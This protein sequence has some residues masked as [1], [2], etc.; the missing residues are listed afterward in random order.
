MK[1][2]SET[3]GPPWRHVNEPAFYFRAHL[4]SDD[5]V[6]NP[7]AGNMWDLE[8]W[9]QMVME[10]SER[11]LKIE[12]DILFAGAGLIAQLERFYRT[13]SLYGLP[14]RR[15]EEFMSW[16]PTI[17]GS[18]RRRQ[19]ASKTSFNPSWSWSGWVGEVGWHGGAAESVKLEETQVYINKLHKLGDRPLVLDRDSPSLNDMTT[20][21]FPFLLIT[22]PTSVFQVLKAVDTPDWVQELQPLAWYRVLPDALTREAV[23]CIYSHSDPPEPMGSVVFDSKIDCNFDQAIDCEFINISSLPQRLDVG[24]YAGQLFF[25]V[26]AVRRMRILSHNVAE[27]IGSGRLVREKSAGSWRREAIVLA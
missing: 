1:A 27:R 15:L 13:R 21:D 10:L 7:L 8:L 6:R 20:E 4:T 11:E 9:I 14:E 24:E 19:D 18:L 16:S 26:L 2:V 22:A 23:Y 3:T 5:E 12:T 25:N 17:P